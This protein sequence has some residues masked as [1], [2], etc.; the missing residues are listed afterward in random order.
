MLGDIL[1]SDIAADAVAWVL[2]FLVGLLG[3][4][5]GGK[6]RAAEILLRLAVAMKD[7]VLEVHQTYV[8]ARKAASEDGKLTDEEAEEAKD[9][10]IEAA[11]AYLGPKGIRE[12][13]GVLG[14]GED[15]LDGWLGGKVEATVA[16][17]KP[18]LSADP[19]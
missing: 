8:E 19:R 7:A 2:G 5:L 15:A 4:K 9:L 10:A 3:S 16:E 1:G 14:I 12:L 13:L 6:G 17:L 18:H 11:K